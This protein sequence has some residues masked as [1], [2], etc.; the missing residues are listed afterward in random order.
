MVRDND[1]WA[2]HIGRI[3]VRVWIWETILMFPGFIL[4]YVLRGDLS[5]GKWFVELV[6]DLFCF[7][8]IIAAITGFPL[9]CIRYL[10][11]KKRERDSD[12][13]RES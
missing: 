6:A 3:F 13:D 10:W 1:G 7:T 12:K 4:Y 2:G 8:P 9:S 11:L 5:H